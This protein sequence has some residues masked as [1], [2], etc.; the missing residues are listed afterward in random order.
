LGAEPVL[1]VHELVILFG[2]G[3][4]RSPTGALLF[5]GSEKSPILREI[6]RGDS[7]SGDVPQADLDGFAD[8]GGPVSAVA[9]PAEVPFPAPK[10]VL[11]NPEQ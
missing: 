10:P 8:L 6:D 11:P 1:L 9:R 3:P 2:A 7:D 4:P 5:S